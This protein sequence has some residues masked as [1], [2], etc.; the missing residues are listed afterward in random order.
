MI[1]K[2]TIETLKDV[3]SRDTF[4]SALQYYFA[5]VIKVEKAFPLALAQGDMIEIEELMH[6]LK[7]SSAT[8]GAFEM[9][10]ICQ[11]IELAAV[12]AQREDITRY[13]DVLFTTLQ[14]T[15]EELTPYLKQ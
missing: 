5:E 15:T 3:V 8:F 12:Q 13:Q 11:Q 14:K 4:V 9:Q 6:S 10:Q 1:D 2:Q 7:S